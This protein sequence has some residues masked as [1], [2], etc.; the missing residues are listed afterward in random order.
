M[1]FSMVCEQV[2]AG[3]LK[4]HGWHHVIEDRQ[5]HVFDLRGVSFV[6]ASHADHSGTGPFDPTPV[7][8]RQ[9]D[10]SESSGGNACLGT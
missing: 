10:A 1:G 8:H 3:R 9:P 2:E 5:V 4:L 7:H 6:P